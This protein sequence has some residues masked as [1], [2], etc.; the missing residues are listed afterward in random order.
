VDHVVASNN[1]K[2]FIAVEGKLDDPAHRRAFVDR[3]Q[4]TQQ[5]LEQSTQKLRQ[6]LPV[7]AE[8]EPVRETTRAMSV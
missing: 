8:P 1:G 2:G 4:A 3:D 7:V 6:D 5:T